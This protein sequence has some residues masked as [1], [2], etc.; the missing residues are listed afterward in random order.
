MRWIN[1]GYVL[2]LLSLTSAAQSPPAPNRTL[3]LQI[4]AADRSAAQQPKRNSLHM[5]PMAGH[6]Q[7]RET[8]ADLGS[9]KAA[10]AAASTHHAVTF[11]GTLTNQGG[12][13]MDYAV[14]HAI[15]LIPSNGACPNVA[16]CWG[17][18]EQ[19]LFD[20][21]RS[22]FIHITDQ[23]VGTNA[24]VRYTVGVSG[25]VNYTIPANPLVDSDIAA[26]V[27][28]MVVKDGGLSGY[29]HE[30]H[31]FL[32]PGQDECFDSTFSVCASNSFCAYHSSADFTDV[33]HVIYSV[34][35]WAGA[36]GCTGLQ[37]D[38]STPSTQNSILSHET[39][40]SI[41]DPDGDA[42]WNASGNLDLYGYEIADQCQWIF[43][44]AT[45]VGFLMDQVYL[46][47]RPY[48]VQSEY[49]NHSNGCTD[50]P[51]PGGE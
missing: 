3:A 19:F 16:A 27:H 18:P 30:Y 12:P 31:V 11:I 46:N 20:L 22:E 13:V 25:R 28:A 50:G 41:T 26:I 36:P 6:R 14:E 2:C 29:H 35:P 33:G 38:G 8:I 42:W 10:Q 51:G 43:F 5:L 1:W 21:G 4:T 44:S 47:G 24:N 34:Q 32:P 17:N 40:E 37:P 49:N 7:N 45:S 15:Y 9:A 39:I 48:Y 23:Y